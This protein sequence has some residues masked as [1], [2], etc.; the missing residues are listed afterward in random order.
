MDLPSNFFLGQM[1]LTPRG[2]YKWGGGSPGQYTEKRDRGHH[3]PEE[4]RPWTVSTLNPTMTLPVDAVRDAKKCENPS[5]ETHPRTHT[6]TPFM[7]LHFTDYLIIIIDYKSDITNGY[8]TKTALFPPFKSF[9]IFQ[10]TF[11]WYP[12]Q[13]NFD[14]KR[15]P[16]IRTE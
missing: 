7:A 15:W 14:L 4:E 1:P 2:V 6:H 10:S 3:W 9:G 13:R 5:K 8:E 11:F 12:F 16:T